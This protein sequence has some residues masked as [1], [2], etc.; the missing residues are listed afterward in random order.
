[1]VERICKNTIRTDANGNV[2]RSFLNS[3]YLVIF[4]SNGKEYVR[5]VSGE[6]FLSDSDIA[7][8]NWGSIWIFRI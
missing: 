2:I 1:M 7:E 4:E 3:L 6:T 8:K 5:G